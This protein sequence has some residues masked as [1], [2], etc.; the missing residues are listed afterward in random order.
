VPYFDLTEIETQ[1]IPSKQR[2]SSSSETAKQRIRRNRASGEHQVRLNEV[3]Q[4]VQE[5]REDAK[6]S[7]EAGES[8]RDLQSK[9]FKSAY[10]LRHRLGF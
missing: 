6:A 2:E 5:D 1:N 10:C 8:R 4:Q 7:G 9:G 3:I